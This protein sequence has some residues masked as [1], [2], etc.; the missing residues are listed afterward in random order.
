MLERLDKIDWAGL[1]HAYGPAHDVPDQI[2]DLSSATEGVRAAARNALYSNI[3]HQGTRYEATA[4]A[5]PFLLELLANESVADRPALA[6]ML[7]AI[8]IGYD[9]S[10]LPGTLPIA[11]MRE[12]ATGGDAVRA[13]APTPG[14]LGYDDESEYLYVESLS[15]QDRM[16]YFRH[17]EVAAYDAVRAGVPLLRELLRDS[18]PELRTQAAY[19]LGWFPEDAAMSGPALLAAAIT[20]PEDGPEQV[21]AAAAALVAAGLLGHR[22]SADLITAPDALLRWAAAVATGLAAGDDTPDAAVAELLGWT[23]SG[24]RDRIP[25]LGG[26]LAGLAGLVIERLN[27]RHAAQTFEALLRTIPAVSGV[28]A[29]PVVASALRMAFPQLPVPEG[30]PYAEL[31]DDQRRLLSVLAGSPRTWLLGE[32]QFGN[33]LLM[34]A[35]CELPASCDE[36]Q[37][38]IDG[39]TMP[40]RR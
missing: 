19:A 21:R 17:I 1:T 15:E 39:G 11:V 38:Y 8:A 28:E 33:F 27:G 20:G 3:F 22:P 13:A 36:L 18:D 34:L 16:Q 40:A 12:Q 5:V 35:G 10:W 31:T 6:R 24:H 4:H 37:T 23:S 14:D 2:R 7:A 26:N 32:H 9:E 25:F 29:M 30:I